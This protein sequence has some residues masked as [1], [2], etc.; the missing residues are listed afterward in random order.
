MLELERELRLTKESLQ[1]TVEELQTANEELQSTNEE[2]QAANEELQSS[3]EELHSVNEEL[4]SVNSEYEVKNRELFDLN[5]DH[6][7]LLNSLDIGTIFLDFEEKIRKFNPAVDNFFKLMPQDIGRPLSHIAYTLGDLQELLED[8]R[9]VLSGGGVVEREVEEARG[10]GAWSLVR[11]MPFANSEAEIDGVVITF[12]DVSRLKNAE[13][14]AAE[15]RDRAQ[16]ANKAKVRFLATVSHELR[17]PLNGVIGAVDIL[18]DTQLEPDQQQLL[19]TADACGRHLSV[20][21]GDILDYT[22]LE[23]RSETLALHN[24]VFNP[25]EVFDNALLMV[26]ERAWQAGL[27]LDALVDNDMPRAICGD[28][29]RLTQVI[30]NLLSNA[31]KFTQEGFVR[32]Q[33]GYSSDGSLKIHVSDSGVGIATEDLD[34]VFCAFTQVG[35]GGDAH[36]QGVG[37]GLALCKQI[38]HAMQGSISVRSQIDEGTTFSL[39]LPVQ[40]AEDALVPRAYDLSG[41]AAFCGTDLRECGLA[42]AVQSVGMQAAF[43]PSF[44]H[45]VHAVAEK[46]SLKPALVFVGGH[47]IASSGDWQVYLDQMRAWEMSHKRLLAVVPQCSQQQWRGLGVQ[48]MVARPLRLRALQRHIVG[49]LD[50][51]STDYINNDYDNND[52]AKTDHEKTDHDDDDRKVQSSPGH[53][54]SNRGTAAVRSEQRKILVVE[55]NP[56]NQQLIRRQLESIGHQVV[57]AENGSLGIDALLSADFDGVFMDLMMPVMD[58]YTATA[59]IRRH[60]Q[61]WSTIPVIALTASCYPEDIERCHSAGF[62]EVLHKPIRKQQLHDVIRKYFGKQHVTASLSAQ[63][64]SGG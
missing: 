12:T 61:T 55:D 62:T 14:S 20:L 52:Y 58:G 6:E 27:S 16:A 25:A 45:L 57:V 3:N 50:S 37:L 35:P 64:P 11:V 43:Y 51:G 21:I 24:E 28:K 41:I 5:E 26:A 36:G 56:V 4:Y 54:S 46:K 59:A 42:E 2:L 32:L 39:T 29:T 17:T 34:S 19:Q 8:V 23:E 22:A 31:V 63:T 18:N 48:S 7:N 10:G 30:S 13:L 60:Q 33:A 44:E 40:I 49:L 38:V 47:L 9:L 1:A 53:Q 15:A